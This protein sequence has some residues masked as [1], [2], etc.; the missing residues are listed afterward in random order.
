MF[1][2]IGLI[3]LLG[4][5]ILAVNAIYIKHLTEQKPNKREQYLTCHTGDYRGQT[6]TIEDW[7]KIAIELAK[8]TKNS[9]LNAMAKHG[10]DD[11]VIGMLYINFGVELFDEE[12]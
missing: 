6:H 4:F 12:D 5:I 7:R 1:N 2:T 8:T 3:F 10:S 9:R 11:D